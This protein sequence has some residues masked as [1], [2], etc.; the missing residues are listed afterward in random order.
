MIGVA[1]ARVTSGKGK[2]GGFETA[3]RKAALQLPD[4]EE[5]VALNESYRGM[6][7]SKRRK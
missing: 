6:A 5:G 3:L 1:M 7:A 2:A 4:V